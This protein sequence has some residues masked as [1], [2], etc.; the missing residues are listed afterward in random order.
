M[1]SHLIW[2]TELSNFAA[3]CLFVVFYCTLIVL[4]LRPGTRRH[5]GVA[6]WFISAAL[7]GLANEIWPIIVIWL[8]GSP[9][10]GIDLL[11]TLAS[12]VPSLLLIV[13]FVA[14]SRALVAERGKSGGE[15]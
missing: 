14:F 8:R 10:H 12:V 15:R 7:V 3:R 5:R 9:S 13:G 1:E 11:E 6:T 4:A 2:L